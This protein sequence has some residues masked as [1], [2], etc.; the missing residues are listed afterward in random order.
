MKAN[1]HTHTARCYHAFGTDEEYVKK[2]IAEGLSILGF[3]DHAPTVYP[4]PYESY[5]KMP[6]SAIADYFSSLSALRNKY[7]DKLEI[8]IGYETEFLPD[9]WDASLELWRNTPSPEYLILGQHYTDF[10]T[11]G[12]CFGDHSYHSPSRTNPALYV[13]ERLTR[14]IDGVV[15]ALST[16]CFSC[17]AHPDLL[18]FLGDNDFYLSEMQRLIDGAKKYG[19]PLEFNL[20]GLREGRF[21]PHREFWELVAK[22][23]LPCVI[24]CDAHSPEELAD[25]R[26]IEEGRKYLAELGIEILEEIELRSPFK[27]LR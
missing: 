3:S 13:H 22:N 12:R 9:T 14:Y 24:G 1:Y 8:H 25:F 2:A 23:K 7:R 11:R 4:E 15:K 27:E 26:N 10:E 5:Y 16:D 21:Y 18:T 19:V 17:L 20:L 6:P